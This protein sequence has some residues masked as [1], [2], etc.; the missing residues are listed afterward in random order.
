MDSRKG[1]NRHQPSH[2]VTEPNGVANLSSTPVLMQ[3][4]S[5][6]TI[7]SAR[8]Q[9]QTLSLSDLQLNTGRKQLINNIML[10]LGLSLDFLYQR[11]HRSHALQRLIPSVFGMFTERQFDVQENTRRYFMNLGHGTILPPKVTQ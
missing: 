5:A 10:F 11:V 2:Y 9:P 6:V 8:D 1:N 4:N 3:L 7:R